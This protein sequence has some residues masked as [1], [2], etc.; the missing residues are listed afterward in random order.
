MKFRETLAVLSVSV[1]DTGQGKDLLTIQDKMRAALNLPLTSTSTLLSRSCLSWCV[2]VCLWGGLIRCKRCLSAYHGPRW[3][4]N[5]R[6]LFPV[7]RLL[8]LLFPKV[9]S[10]YHVAQPHPCSVWCDCRL[11]HPLASH[12]LCPS[13]P[14]PPPPRGPA[15]GCLPGGTG[16]PL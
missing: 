3:A 14:P 8:P 2:C 6:H 7:V 11:S 15:T 12:H 4:L 9:A 10:P 16:E 5:R 1:L 13:P